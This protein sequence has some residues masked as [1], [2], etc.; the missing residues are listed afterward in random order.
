MQNLPNPGFYTR[1]KTVC[2]WLLE[3][4]Y[5]QFIFSFYFNIK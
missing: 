4:S 5:F 1:A 2:F 3:K